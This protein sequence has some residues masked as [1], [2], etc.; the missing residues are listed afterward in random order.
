MNADVHH[1]Q[2]HGYQS[3]NNQTRNAG[4][5]KLQYQVSPGTSLTGF[6]GVIW[7][8]AN[9]PN[10]NATR[11]QMYGLLAGY[12]CN[13]VAATVT[14]PAILYPFTG[15]GINFL[16]TNNSNPYLYLN[17]EYNFYH[18]PT[19]FEYVGVHSKLGKGFVFDI[20]PYTYNYDNSEKYANAVPITDQTTINGS[21]TYNGQAINPCNVQTLKKG[22]LAYP[23]AVDKYNSYRKYGETSE[24]T[25][26]S[27]FGILRTGLWY[28]WANTNR[29]QFPSDPLDGYIDSPL[30][31]FN[32]KFVTNSYQPYA[33]YQLQIGSRLTITP[34]VKLAYYTIGTKQYADNGG[35]IGALPGNT[36]GFVTNGGSYFST[37][38]SAT[39]NYHLRNNWTAY[40]QAAQGSIVPP[41]SVF[42]FTQGA[43]G[44]PVGTL[45]KQQKNTTYQAGTVVKLKRVTLDADVFHIHFDNSYSSFTPIATGE[46]VFYVQPSSTSLGLEGES[47]IYLGFGLGVYL[48]AS[49]DKAT[50]KGTLTQSCTGTAATGCTSS[51]AQYTFTAPSGLNVA[52]TPSDVETEGITYQ[53]KVW[54]I[55]LFNKRVGTEY[56]DVGAYHNQTTIA[57]FTLTNANINYTVR[58]GG[59]FNNTKVQLSFNNLFNEHSI[60]SIAKAGSPITETFAANGTSYINPFLTVGQT[61]ISGQDAISILPACSI[62]LTVTFGHTFER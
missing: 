29:H 7:L 11:C 57:P 39:I 27:R 61:P 50:Y 47:N 22:V 10:F 58:S 28:E 4:D 56:E 46:P 36:A 16:L 42:D 51:T 62:M 38:P 23:C 2:S 19:D 59:R 15:T 55:G 20:K 37:L 3:L 33:E 35:K 6:S 45:P 49:Y 21:K 8:D 40:V 26:V 60:T 1:L 25:Q 18:V 44:T 12:N 48:N 14:A 54:D 9:T 52:Q 30:P 32:E 41:S 53:H 17:D 43:N 13:L 5:I 34:G 24:L 31:N